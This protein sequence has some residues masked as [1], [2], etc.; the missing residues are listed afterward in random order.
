[1]YSLTYLQQ[2]ALITVIFISNCACKIFTFSKI[3]NR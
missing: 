3:R 2:I 1:M